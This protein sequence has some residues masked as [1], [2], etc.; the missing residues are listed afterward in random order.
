MAYDGN[1]DKKKTFVD[2]GDSGVFA[3]V[4]FT[5]NFL[6][7]SFHRHYNKFASYF[8]ANL[9]FRRLVDRD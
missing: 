3:R 7:R 4:S 8:A 1:I 9:Q 5:P 2:S 6:S